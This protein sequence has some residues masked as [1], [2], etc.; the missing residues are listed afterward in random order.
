[1][2]ERDLQV[3]VIGKGAREHALAWQLSRARSVKHVFVFP[4]NAGT[5]EVAASNSTVG[6][7]ALEGVSSWEYQDLAKRAKEIGIGLVGGGPERVGMELMD[8]GMGG[9]IGCLS[10]GLGLG[11]YEGVNK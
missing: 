6:I 11:N 5:H 7:S 9:W 4:G 8:E 2:T 3:L 1:M 10:L